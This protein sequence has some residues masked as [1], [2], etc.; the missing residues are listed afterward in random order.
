M[1]AKKNFND[2]K[3][4]RSTAVLLYTVLPTSVNNQ[5]FGFRKG[6]STELAITDL[7][8]RIIKNTDNGYYTCLHIF[9]FVQSVR[10][11]KSVVPNLF[12]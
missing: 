10:H 4:R 3:I 12:L 2:P 9:R 5:Q 1:L 7:H 11:S 6:Y 8:N